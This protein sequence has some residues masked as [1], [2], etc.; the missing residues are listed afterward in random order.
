MSVRNSGITRARSRTVRTATRG[1]LTALGLTAAFVAVP[2]VASAHSSGGDA[3]AQLR[4]CESGGDYGINT[5]NGF[6]GAYQFDLG[7]WRSVGGSGYPHQASPAT[8]DA[9]AATLQSQRGWAPWPAC[10]RSLGLGSVSVAPAPASSSALVVRSVSDRATR[11]ETRV[12]PSGYQG[13][14]LS[15]DRG[16]SFRDDVQSLQARLSDKGYA[17]AV[18]GYF[19]P[20]TQSAVV[21]F[22]RDAGIAVDGVVGPQTWGAAF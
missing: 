4:A 3:F 21:A 6:Y 18:D 11:S 19:G 2:G 22:Q 7:T 5:G 13:V 9:L 16:T 1:A 12:A 15:T 17:L 14:L 20:E 8:Q 10:S